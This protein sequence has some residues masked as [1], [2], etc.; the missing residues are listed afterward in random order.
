MKCFRDHKPPTS[1]DPSPRLVYDIARACFLPKFLCACTV[2]EHSRHWLKHFKL[3]TLSKLL[4]WHVKLRE[5]RIRCFLWYKWVLSE[6]DVPYKHIRQS[7]DNNASYQI[8]QLC[9]KICFKYRICLQARYIVIKFIRTVT[10][11]I[12]MD[13]MDQNKTTITNSTTNS[14]LHFSQLAGAISSSRAFSIWAVD[15]TLGWIY[16]GRCE[17]GLYTG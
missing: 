15:G 2:G 14:R 8:F 7:T 5:R 13:R 12:Q 11:E 17:G 10:Y 16:S 3:C 9:Q 1:P 4:K 6:D